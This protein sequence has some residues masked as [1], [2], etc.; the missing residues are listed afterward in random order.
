[1]FSRKE[2]VVTKVAENDVEHIKKKTR[3]ELELLKQQTERLKLFDAS[4]DIDF[5]IKWY[6]IESSRFSKLAFAYGHKS[7]I[8]R[9]ILHAE[10]V[11]G[12]VVLGFVVHALAFFALVGAYYQLSGMLSEHYRVDEANKEA[13]RESMA[14][15]REGLRQSIES[16][17]EMERKLDKAFSAMEEQNESLSA[18]IAQLSLDA[19]RLHGQVAL[20]EGLVKQLQEQQK[21]LLATAE[22]IDSA[23][24]KLGNDIESLS[25]VI[26]EK[27]AALELV[28]DSIVSVSQRALKMEREASLNQD[29]ATE[30]SRELNEQV[31]LAETPNSSCDAVDTTL[32]C[33]GALQKK[34]AENA[35]IETEVTQVLKRSQSIH[36][37]ARRALA[38]KSSLPSK[39]QSQ[40][41]VSPTPFS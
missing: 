29:S 19:G 2:V 15:L 3:N 1:M 14:T 20:L 5:A 37:R 9:Q 25:L 27:R 40:E 16:F 28:S 24:E 18:T 21:K 38:L 13:I 39:E 34:P 22:K 12:A 33:S 8:D 11:A 4:I 26:R 32:G 7:W 6:E 30:L 41:S 36:E 10:V 35:V 31:V 23:A 17:N